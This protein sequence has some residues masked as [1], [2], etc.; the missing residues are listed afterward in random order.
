[1]LI[2]QVA[3]GVHQQVFWGLA[4]PQ[5]AANQIPRLSDTVDDITKGSIVARKYQIGNVQ[6]S[7]RARGPPVALDSLDNFDISHAE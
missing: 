6:P 7:R 3:Q 1:M 2:N 4:I 5:H